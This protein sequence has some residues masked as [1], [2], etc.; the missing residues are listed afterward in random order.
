M[1]T[2][3]R[4]TERR[5][6][7]ANVMLLKVSKQ[8]RR[9]DHSVGAHVERA[10]RRVEAHRDARSR[11]VSIDQVLA[12]AH[13]LSYFTSAP[14]GW[15]PGAELGMYRPPRPE[16]QQWTKSHLYTQVPASIV[17]LL[18]DDAQQQLIGNAAGALAVGGHHDAKGAAATLTVVGATDDDDDVSREPFFPPSNSSPGDPFRSPPRDINRRVEA[19]TNLDLDLNTDLSDE[20]DILNDD[21]E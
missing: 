5:I 13:R 1:Q 14:P 6:Q 17:A 8:L 19:P 10:Q 20:D 2:R 18:P 11:S 9:V 15:Q 3:I 7:D 21:S 16:V 12:Y 4:E